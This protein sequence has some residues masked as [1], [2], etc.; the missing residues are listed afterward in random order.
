[1][2]K[3]G[4]Y[5]FWAIL[6]IMIFGLHNFCLAWYI[7]MENILGIGISMFFMIVMFFCS[8][9]NIYMLTECKD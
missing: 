4:M 8:I 5:W 9:L 7:T 6:D 1:M 2:N 3:R